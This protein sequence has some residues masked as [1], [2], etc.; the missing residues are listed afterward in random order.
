MSFPRMR[1]SSLAMRMDTRSP[2][3]GS[4]AGRGYD[5]CAVRAVGC[6]G[7]SVCAQAGGI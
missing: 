1:E 4:G 7:S 3:I 5:T 6:M 2:P